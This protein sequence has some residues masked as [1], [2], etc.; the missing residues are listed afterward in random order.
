MIKVT[1]SLNEVAAACAV[2]D[3][4][5]EIRL[6]IPVDWPLLRLKIGAKDDIMRLLQYL[7]RISCQRILFAPII[8]HLL[9]PVYGHLSL[10]FAILYTHYSESESS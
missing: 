10:P 1:L 5:L 6:R 4:Q 3:H 9:Q 7:K 2:D 8:I